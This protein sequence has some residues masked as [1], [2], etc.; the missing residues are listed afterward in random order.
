[1]LG[2]IKMIHHASP[3]RSQQAQYT[4]GAEIPANLHCFL[5]L[6]SIGNTLKQLKGGNEETDD[7]R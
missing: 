5:I 1:M 7:K 3:P 4:H 2:M 6:L